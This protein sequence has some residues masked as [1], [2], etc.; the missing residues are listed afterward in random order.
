MQRL[1]E[2]AEQVARL[3]A[4]NHRNPHAFHEGKS[5][6]A[7]ELRKLARELTP[8]PVRSIDLHRMG[9]ERS[10]RGACGAPAR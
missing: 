5:E 1:L 10:A 6:I 8:R 9:P 3:P 4:Y 7:A 2:L